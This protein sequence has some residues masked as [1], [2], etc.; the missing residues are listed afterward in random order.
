MRRLSSATL[1]KNANINLVYGCEIDPNCYVYKV[2]DGVKTLVK[3]M[4]G[5][6]SLEGNEA[7]RAWN[8]DSMRK[9]CG[10]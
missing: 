10:A 1:R 7:S 3:V 2:V 8:Q 4:P 9:G 5:I 6:T